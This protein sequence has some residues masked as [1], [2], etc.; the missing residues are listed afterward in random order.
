MDLPNDPLGGLLAMA[1]NEYGGERLLE[2]AHS[3]FA[4][5]PTVIADLRH[6][7]AAL[8]K[9]LDRTEHERDEARTDAARQYRRVAGLDAEV[10]RLRRQPTPAV[11]CGKHPL[12]GD[13]TCI[14]EAG[15]ESLHMGGDPSVQWIDTLE[16]RDGLV[17]AEIVCGG[18]LYLPPINGGNPDNPWTPRL[19]CSLPDGHAV[20]HSGPVTW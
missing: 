9:R 11:R 17:D 16:D 4:E 19:E 13:L 5:D 12:T 20:R 8:E 14:R 3:L 15:H 2:R 1:G 7:V 18:Y 6:D 10:V